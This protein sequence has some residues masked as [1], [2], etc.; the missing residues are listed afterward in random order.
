[1]TRYLVALLALF[2]G[3]LV[4]VGGAAAGNTKKPPKPSNAT[5]A[6]FDFL[7]GANTAK[8]ALC[9]VPV[10][11]PCTCAGAQMSMSVGSSVI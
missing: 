10:P 1:M 3:A 6:S 11:S 7:V 2:L 5:A 9:S 8:F 4:A